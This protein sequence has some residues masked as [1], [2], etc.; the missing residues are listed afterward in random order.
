MRKEEV[1]RKVFIVILCPVLLFL[2]T[3]C[4]SAKSKAVEGAVV[5]TVL[6][7]AAGAGIGSLSGNEGAGAGIGAAVG[8][9]G[10]RKSVV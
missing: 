8:A 4:Q 7:A 9:I 2:T 10:D 5:G 1:M 3:G 6:G